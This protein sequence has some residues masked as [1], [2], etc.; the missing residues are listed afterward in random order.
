MKSAFVS[1]PSRNADFFL[2]GS[3]QRPHSISIN[4]PLKNLR[5]A[6]AEANAAVAALAQA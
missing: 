1:A 2:Q 5:P 3:G 4:L 6:E